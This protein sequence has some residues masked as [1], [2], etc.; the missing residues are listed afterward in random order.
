M[1]NL[2]NRSVNLLTA[3][4]CIK[5]KKLDVNTAELSIKS[6]MDKYKRKKYQASFES[7]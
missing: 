4:V 7:I 3:G 5:S 2:L 1:N 6:V